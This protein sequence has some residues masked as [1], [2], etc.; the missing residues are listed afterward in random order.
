MFCKVFISVKP[1]EV[2][3]LQYSRTCHSTTSI[4]D[5]SKFEDCGIGLEYIIE[6]IDKK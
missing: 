3:N 5:Q 4:W 6:I 2:S 1:R